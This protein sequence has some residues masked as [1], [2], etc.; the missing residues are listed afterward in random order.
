VAAILG[1]LWLTSC[2]SPSLA[3]PSASGSEP[4]ASS[5][6][7]S[8]DLRSPAGTPIILTERWRAP[9]GGTYYLRQS[10]SCVWFAGFSADA[11][12][13]G[14]ERTA[15]WVNSYFGHLDSDFTLRGLWAD[16]PWGLDNGTG[17]LDWRLT[18]AQVDGEEA[19]T[20]EVVAV[21]GGFGADF[22]VKPE[23]RVELVG[24]LA[25]G[26]DCDL[27][28]EADDGT[29]YQLMSIPDGWTY[30]SP[31]GFLSPDGEQITESDSFAIRGEVARGNGFCGPGRLLFVDQIEAPPAS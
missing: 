26:A 5:A 28:V 30:T 6:C 17:E 22:L 15:T 18:F 16:L 24:R 4:A 27:A 19:T 7:R 31:P 13:P 3:P 11:P 25:P 10:G 9:D 8:V 23:A 12:S 14:G 2:T 1:M 29:E 20:L 21:S